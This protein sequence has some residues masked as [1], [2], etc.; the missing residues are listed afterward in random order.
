MSRKF[1]DL[2]NLCP[3]FF[4]TETGCMQFW[5]VVIFIFI[6]VFPAGTEYPILGGTFAELW[7]D[8]L[9]GHLP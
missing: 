6:T 3:G 7:V 4:V 8:I 1:C 5:E 9:G 2:K